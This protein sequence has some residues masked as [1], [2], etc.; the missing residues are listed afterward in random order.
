[1]TPTTRFRKYQSRAIETAQV[2]E[3]L[4][5]LVRE[6]RAAGVRGEQLGLM[7]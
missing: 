3:E 1:M 5:Q 6:M 7:D 2:I 4:I